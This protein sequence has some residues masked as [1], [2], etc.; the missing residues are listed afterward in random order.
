MRVE[1]VIERL[2]YRPS[3]IAR[4]L[5]HQRSHTLGVVATGL[6]YYGPSRTLVG[7]EKQVRAQGYS[8]LLDLLHH[9]ETEDVERILNRLLS[10]QVDGILWAVP[11]IGNNRA[12]LRTSNLLL[13]VPFVFL[14]MDPLLEL[15]LATIDNRQGGRLA[16]EH[17]ISQGYRN[18]G[19]ITGPL[20]WWE[21]RQRQLG[22]Q[23]ALLSAGL[24]AGDR[25][26]LEGNWSAA[27]GEETIRLLLLQ[28]PEMQAVFAS[29]DQMALGVLRAAHTIGRQVPRDLA[30][31][32]FDNIPESAYFWPPLTTVEQPL[33][34]LGCKA[35][36][37]LTE[38]ID[39]EGQNSTPPSQLSVSL[40]P[41]LI[42]R[43]SSVLL[44]GQVT[45]GGSS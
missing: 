32:G 15:P 23:D 28:F 43:D 40:A 8:L 10:R 11:E 17:L 1:H 13:Q 35:V 5:I 36:E 39:A 44:E 20:E 3:A 37:K 30:V 22:W 19:M 25:Q 26:V 2:G 34:D 27:S 16:A 38:L 45:I 29:N 14:N 9:P 6:D 41:E 31:V 12:W 7:I 18:I 42:V 33:V 21:A 24:P 4:S